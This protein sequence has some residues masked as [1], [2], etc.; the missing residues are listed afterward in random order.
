M[1]LGINGFFA[2]EKRTCRRRRKPSPVG[3]VFPVNRAEFKLSG[4]TSSRRSLRA[5]A[6]P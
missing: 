1:R 4:Q 2:L 5:L 6:D 3:C